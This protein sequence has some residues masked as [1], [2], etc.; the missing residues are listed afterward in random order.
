MDFRAILLEATYQLLR[1]KG[2]RGTRRQFLAFGKKTVNL[3][4]KRGQLP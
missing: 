3:M 1:Q 4:R 2:Y